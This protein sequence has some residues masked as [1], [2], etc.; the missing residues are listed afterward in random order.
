[1]LAA[2]CLM[3]FYLYAFASMVG[4]KESE[5][6]RLESIFRKLVLGPEVV[7]VLVVCVLAAG[8]RLDDVEWSTRY[9]F[10]TRMIFS[11]LTEKLSRSGR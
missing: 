11:E 7:G 2:A 4:P 1:M 10:V 3:G 5:A 8:G 6:A 9:P